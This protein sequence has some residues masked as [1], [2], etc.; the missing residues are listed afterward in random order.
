MW[1]I[2]GDAGDHLRMDR[3]GSGR[4]VLVLCACGGWFCRR[5]ECAL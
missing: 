2:N 4:D 5:Y 3:G 1:M